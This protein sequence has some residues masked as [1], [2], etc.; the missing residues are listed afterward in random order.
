ML[1]SSKV[2]HLMP[3]DPQLQVGPV[4]QVVPSLLIIQLGYEKCRELTGPDFESVFYLDLWAS[5]AKLINYYMLYGCVQ[6]IILL[7]YLPSLH[8]GT[9][10]G[11]L[12][13]PGVYSE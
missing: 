1:R 6:C 12:P 4:S 13:F 2:V 11:A 7:H 10:W 9:S 3:G 8:S 5:N